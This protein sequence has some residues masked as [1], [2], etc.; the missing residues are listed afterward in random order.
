MHD[1]KLT[2]AYFREIQEENDYTQ[3]AFARAAGIAQ[4]SI[5]K[6]LNEQPVRIQTLEKAIM[7]LGRDTT[8]FYIRI[9]L[10]IPPKPKPP[11]GAPPPDLL[12][13]LILEGLRHLSTDNKTKALQYIKSLSESS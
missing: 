6:I 5:N 13:R 9:G 11:N 12:D 2:A 8:D 7:G 10:I 3:S 4:S 1:L